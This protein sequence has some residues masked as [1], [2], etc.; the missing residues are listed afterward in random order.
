[1]NKP[2][3][4]C[5]MMTSVDGRIDCAMTEQIESGDEYYEALAELGCP[6]LLM[7]R[8]TMQLHYAAAEPFVAKEP[9]PIGRQAVHVA[10]RAGGYLVAV[11]THGSLC[12][13]AGEFDGQPLLVITSEKCAAEY[14]IRWPER[15]F[16]G[17]RSERSVSICR[18][19]WE[20]ASGAFGVER[21]AVVGGGN[22]NGH[23][24]RPGCSMR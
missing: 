14:L 6:S 21:L 8:V 16:R 20:S 12:W 15:E 4:V 2:Y 9:A 10:R 5:H 17:L 3:I 18:K 1:M 13:P 7:G 24:L 22:I 19:R 11:D 23:F